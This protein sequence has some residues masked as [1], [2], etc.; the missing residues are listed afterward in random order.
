MN[1]DLKNIKSVKELKSVFVNVFPIFFRGKKHLGIFSM[2]FYRIEKKYC[3]QKFNISFSIHEDEF[4]LKTL[5]KK[6]IHIRIK[7]FVYYFNIYKVKIETDKVSGYPPQNVCLAKFNFEKDEVLAPIVYNLIY[8]KFY[9]GKVGKL[10]KYKNV[11]LTCYFR[12]TKM[13]SMA[14]TVRK[15]NVTDKFKEKVKIFFAKVLSLITPKSKVILLYEKEANK[16]EESASVL[17]E[18]LIDLG[19]KN[20]KFVIRK[21][22]L[23]NSFIKDKYKKNIIYAFTFKHYYNFF[24]C[25]KFIGSET[26]PHSIELRAANSFITRKMIK[27]K[28]KQVFLQHGVMY[29][30]ALNPTSRSG[31]LKGGNEMPNDAKI[32]VSSKL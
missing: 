23:H 28:Y 31:F 20:A 29:M 5:F 24:K 19:Y 26:I 27:K 8:Y 25:K 2:C 10:Y 30:V 4:K 15:N 12:Q 16:Y 11:D 7:G 6:G 1:D 17:Y 21:N 9:L 14:L 32:V 3:K 22:S 18:R 13:N